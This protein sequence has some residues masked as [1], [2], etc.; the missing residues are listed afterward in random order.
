MMLTL[1][2]IAGIVLIVLSLYLRFWRGK[3]K[4]NRRNAAGVET[5]NTYRGSLFINWLENTASFLSI[6]FMILGIIILLAAYF[7][8]KDIM[9]LDHF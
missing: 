5:F 6:L 3:R 4:F 7:D 2:Y 1:F 9:R 8:A